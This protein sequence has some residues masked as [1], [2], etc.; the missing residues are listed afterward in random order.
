MQKTTHVQLPQHLAF[1]TCWDMSTLKQR[2]RLA[3]V[4]K[5]WRLLGA[6]SWCTLEVNFVTSEELQQQVRW[7]ESIASLSPDT[8]RAIVMSVPK[9]KQLT[10]LETDECTPTAAIDSPLFATL[11]A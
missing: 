1:K 2:G 9:G 7:L 10:P 4:C 6:Q 11:V 8:A 3:A 5:D